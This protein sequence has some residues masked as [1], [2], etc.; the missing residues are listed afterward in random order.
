MTV[1]LLDSIIIFEHLTFLYI[2]DI[3]YD[4][5]YSFYRVISLYSFIPYPW[6]HDIS[7]T[8]YV[9]YLL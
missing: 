3:L 6:I 5:I 1:I 2:N 9:S 8:T 7:S 4:I